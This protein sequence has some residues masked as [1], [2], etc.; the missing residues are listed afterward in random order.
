MYL[1]FLPLNNA[2]QYTK[3]GAPLSTAESL[4]PDP[5]T[6]GGIEHTAARFLPAEQWISMQHAGEVMMFP[7]QVY[8]LSIVA[9]FL[10][11][12]RDS[13]RGEELQQQRQ[14]LRAFLRESE[15]YSPWGTRCISPVMIARSMRDGRSI[16]ALDKPGWEVQEAGRSGDRERCSIV[17]F[18]KEGP[19]RVDIRWKREVLEEERRLAE[20]MEERGK[21]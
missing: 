1:Y 17:D 15:E 8:L 6:D 7:P 21:L 18:R 13:T 11:P 9:E 12:T 4:I 19:R 20:Q 14:K 10:H 16:M 5:T 3:I 2:S